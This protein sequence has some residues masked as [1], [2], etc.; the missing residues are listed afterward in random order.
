MSKAKQNTMYRL[1]IDYGTEGWRLDESEYKTVDLAV[2][3]SM[4]ASYGH[5]FVIVKVIDWEAK[6]VYVEG[7]LCRVVLEVDALDTWGSD[8]TDCNIMG[9]LRR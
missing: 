3:G 9:M 4:A 1:F 5:P 2:R 6:E 8:S 7:E